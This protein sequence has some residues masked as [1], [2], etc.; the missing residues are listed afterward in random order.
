MTSIVEEILSFWFKEAG[1][2]KWFQQ[3]HAFDREVRIHFEGINH[4]ARKGA[5]DLWKE[6]PNSCLALIIVIDQFSRNIHR[7]SAHAWSAD[8]YG[9]ML[10][11]LEI[12]RKYD[13][14]F[15]FLKR[16]FIYMP[17]MHSETLNDQK[18]SVLLFKKLAEDWGDDGHET[19]KFAHRHHDIILR[20]G[21]F[22]HRNNVLKRKS[23]N[24]EIEFLKEPLSSF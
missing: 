19:L 7:E 2:S 11:R 8:F 6:R 4:E 22:P 23:T 9:I 14:R 5:L 3:D 1:P 17:F 13:Q 20:F 21:R 16:K 24:S 10:S 18:Y 12:D 15:D